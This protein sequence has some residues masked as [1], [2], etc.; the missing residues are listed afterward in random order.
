MYSLRRLN[1]EANSY[2]P[3][4]EKFKETD[5]K[6]KKKGVVPLKQDL[7]QPNFQHVKKN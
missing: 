3:L 5:L 7:T 4:N 1:A 2:A 6:Q